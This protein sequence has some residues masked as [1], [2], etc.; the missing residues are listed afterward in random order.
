MKR[1]LATFLVLM[2]FVGSAL[3]QGAAAE[4]IK[5]KAIRQRDINNEQQGVTPP[6]TPPP[7][8]ASTSAPSGPQGISSVQQQL[9]DKLQTDLAAIKPGFPVTPEQKQQ[10]QNDFAALAKGTTK[11]SKTRLTKLADD[12][13]AALAGNNISVKDHAQLAKDINIVM[14]SGNPNLS[15]AQTQT[16]VAAAQTVLKAGGVAGPEAIAVTVDLKAIVTDLQ[17][18]KSKLYQ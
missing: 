13:S 9:I 17:Q 4:M 2:L 1:F 12:L 7:G 11:P 6:G 5:Q 16:F 18:S 3:A 8:A 15:P 10:L 14:N